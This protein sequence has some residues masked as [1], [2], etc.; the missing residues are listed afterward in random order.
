[1]KKPMRSSLKIVIL[2]IAALLF[3]AVL[4]SGALSRNSATAAGREY[5]EQQGYALTYQA[6]EWSKHHSAF[7][8]V[9]HDADGNEY[10]FSIIA[11]PFPKQ[12]V[13]DPI[14]ESPPY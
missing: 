4:P 7:M 13:Y 8:V 5:V 14:L 1:M 3:I 2:I 9:F 6:T 11:G 10:R 12:V